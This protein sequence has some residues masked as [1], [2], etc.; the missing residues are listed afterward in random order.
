MLK[1]S[2]LHLQNIFAN[3]IDRL[4]EP[5]KNEGFFFFFSPGVSQTHGEAQ[6]NPQVEVQPTDRPSLRVFK[7]VLKHRPISVLG[8]QDNCDLVSRSRWIE[9]ETCW[10]LCPVPLPLDHKK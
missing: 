5:T 4:I 1:Y 10:R 9:P 7:W 2:K 8:D 6:I 3:P